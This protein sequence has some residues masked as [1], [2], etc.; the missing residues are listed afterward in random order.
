MKGLSRSAI[1][2]PQSPII[3]EEH[4]RYIEAR[5][6]TDL[7]AFITTFCDQFFKA[8]E[9]YRYGRIPDRYANDKAVRGLIG[10]DKASKY[11]PI[12][13]PRE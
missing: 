13:Q 1:S 12:R 10:I 8:G 7:S 11:L 4:V 2:V 5:D 6:C 9:F 3:G